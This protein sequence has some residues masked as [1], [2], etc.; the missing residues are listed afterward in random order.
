[1]SQDQFAIAPSL[2]RRPAP[3]PEPP[4]EIELEPAPPRAFSVYELGSGRIVDTRTGDPDAFTPAKGQAVIVGEFHWK[5]HRVD[6]GTGEAVEEAW[7][8]P[9]PTR[10]DAEARVRADRAQFLGACDWT[11]LL[12][13]PLSDAERAAWAAYRTALR[14]IPEQ[15]GFPDAVDWPLPP[16]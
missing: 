3:V 14:Q 1:M 4:P 2:P 7:A 11:Q 10:E 12:D 8:P 13:A 16:G 6:L 15:K 9:A 5:T